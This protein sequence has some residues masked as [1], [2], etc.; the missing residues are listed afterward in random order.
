MF[1]FRFEAVVVV[2]AILVALAVSAAP[3]AQAKD[4]PATAFAFLLMP[5]W[6]AVF[7][8]G[9]QINIAYSLLEKGKAT[10]HRASITPQSGPARDRAFELWFDQ[11]AST[12]PITVRKGDVLRAIPCQGNGDV[13][14]AR[15]YVSGSKTDLVQ[16]SKTVE[17][18]APG[19]PCPDR[20]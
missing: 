7:N 12:G 13:E 11:G 3:G 15:L 19:K 5:N 6:K 4:D 16:L 18:C 1:L 17:L 20:R 10:C 8:A 9:A 14:L 2:G